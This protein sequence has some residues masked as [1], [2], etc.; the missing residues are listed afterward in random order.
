MYVCVK[1]GRVLKIAKNGVY[2]ELLDD[3]GQPYKI[4]STDRWACPECGFEIL[5]TAPNA[6]VQAYQTAPYSHFKDRVD[7]IQH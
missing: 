7:Y 4:Y 5:V 2:A 3:A 6:I 1:D